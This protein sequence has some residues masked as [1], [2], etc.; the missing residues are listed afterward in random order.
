MPGGLCPG[1]ALARALA[2]LGEDHLDGGIRPRDDVD[3][4]ELAYAL[5]GRAARVRRRLNR[6]HVAAG[7]G[8]VSCH[9]H[10]EE[11]EVVQQAEPLS[12]SWCL[13]CHRDPRPNLRPRS[14]VTNMKWAPPAGKQDALPKRAS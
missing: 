3:G 5:R 13:D 12:M 2:V 11:M 10:V 4:D 7:V 6:A 14:E 9:G 8:C 1:A